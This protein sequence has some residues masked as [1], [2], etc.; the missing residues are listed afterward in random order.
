MDANDD[1]NSQLADQ[2]YK[3]DRKRQVGSYLFDEELSDPETAIYNDPA[4]GK[5]IVAARGTEVGQGFRTAARDLLADVGIA[6]GT[7]I[8]GY[9]SRFNRTQASFEKARDKYGGDIS[10]TGHSLGGA[11]AAS[12]AAKNNIGATTFNRGA[13]LPRLSD[14]RCSRLNPFKTPE[15]C[16]KIDNVRVK[17]DGVSLLGRVFGSGRWRK[18]IKGSG[19][20]LKRHGIANFTG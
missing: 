10:A 8:G 3:V 15:Y 16:S 12:L 17:G 9:G 2:A 7:N 11:L 18:R 5:T 14:L 4:S 13:G 20:L 1:I 6:T 19:G